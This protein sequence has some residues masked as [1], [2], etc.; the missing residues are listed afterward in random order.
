MR[1]VFRKI[2]T[3]LLLLIGVSVAYLATE[4][5]LTRAPLVLCH[6]GYFSGRPCAEPASGISVVAF[7]PHDPQQIETYGARWHWEARPHEFYLVS[8]A[9]TFADCRESRTSIWTGGDSLWIE[10][11]LEEI[12]P[13]Q[14]TRMFLPRAQS[15]T[16]PLAPG[17]WYVKWTRDG[18]VVLDER[19]AITW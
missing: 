10:T 2:G 7:D 8:E 11:D 5:L 1:S 13:A 4:P 19:L 18:E 9:S 14:C 16:I 12:P 3:A 6:V 17:M 15:W